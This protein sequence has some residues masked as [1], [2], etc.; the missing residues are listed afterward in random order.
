MSIECEGASGA[1][2]SVLLIVNCAEMKEATAF[3]R[4]NTLYI[5]FRTVSEHVDIPFEY[6]AETH[7]RNISY[8]FQ[9]EP[10]LIDI[11]ENGFVF[12]LHRRK[13]MDFQ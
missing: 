7:T 1:D 6:D 11:N 13:T 10:Y 4:N 5:P 12:G 9:N 3:S 2:D 8:T